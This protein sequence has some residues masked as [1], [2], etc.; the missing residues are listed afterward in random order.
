MENCD[1]HSSANQMSYIAMD[2]G[3][4][5]LTKLKSIAF[6]IKAL[7]RFKQLRR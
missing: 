4:N 1:I 7:F 2:D 5:D 6:K 3:A